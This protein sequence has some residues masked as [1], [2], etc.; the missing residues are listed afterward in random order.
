VNV[1]NVSGLH[2]SY[3]GRSIF[4]GVSFAIDE[5][6]KVGFIGANG[7]GKST[8]FRIV[9]GAEGPDG[10]DLAVRRGIRTAWLAQEP[11]FVAGHN[12]RE[13]VSEGRPEL[14]DALADYEALSAQLSAPHADHER[15]VQRHAE[16]AATLDRLGGWDW[17]H[18][19][20]A[21]LT[22]LGVTDWHRTVE[23][24]SGGEAKR[25][26]LARALLSEPELLLLDEP[27][28][29]LDADTVQ[30]L[31]DLLIDYPGAVMLITH[32]RYFLDRVVDRMLEVSSGELTSYVG[33][34]TEYLQASAEK[35]ERDAVLDEKR[36]RLVAQELEW[37][38]RSPPARTGKQRA[39]IQ[40]AE[41]L[42]KESGTYRSKQ[43]RDLELLTPDTTRLGRTVL[44]LHGI[45]KS[46]GERVLIRD[47]NTMLRAGERVGIIGPNGAGKTTLIRI[48]LGTES[49]DSGEVELGV[50]TRVAY[51]DQMRTQVDPELSVYEAAGNTDWVE[52]GGRRTHLRSYLESFLFPTARQQQKVSSLSG[53]ERN[54]LML[55]KLLMQPSN[56]LILDEP[57][58]DLDLITLQVLEAALVDYP[59]CVLMVTHD[60]FFLDKI[61]TALFVF[62]GDGVVHRHEGGFELY[63]RLREQR[64]AAQAADDAATKQEQRAAVAGLKSAATASRPTA[65]SQKSASASQKSAS[66]SQKS[67]AAPQK[68][69]WKEARE[70]ES[71]EAR[72]LEAEAERERLTAL[73]ADPELYQ[74]AAA[75]AQATADFRD[76]EEAVD[77]LYARWAELE[78]RAER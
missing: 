9:A 72:I 40:R 64:A 59:G 67:V 50:N 70:L 37:A 2:K 45:S 73:L 35:A 53:G 16:L 76:A 28:N 18:R 69:T 23:A 15:L 32:D 4:D 68:L 41:A 43:S 33:G 66:A 25:V 29:H 11:E 7:S 78:E 38:K 17:T 77:A 26:A 44:N 13:A 14:A 71:L 30:Y 58:N 51:F 31:E 3:G 62:E 5:G 57:T 36:R 74:D 55:A 46:F 34:Y 6:E 19:V 52:I 65:A 61:A 1:L 75:A 54:R 20:E 12:I 8:L 22:R 49:A 10:G 42:A 56:V 21:M 24:L 60:R 48:I 47:F 63:R 39:R 27:T